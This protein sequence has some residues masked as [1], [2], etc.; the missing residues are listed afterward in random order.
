MCTIAEKPTAND[1]QWRAVQDIQGMNVRGSVTLLVRFASVK[2][3]FAD[4]RN[5]FSAAGAG[6]GKERCLFE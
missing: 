3:L 2:L 1:I 4:P 5:C 6:A